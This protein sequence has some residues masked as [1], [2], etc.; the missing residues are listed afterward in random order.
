MIFLEKLIADQHQT[1]V[2]ADEIV[3]RMPQI[4]ETKVYAAKKGITNEVRK[5]LGVLKER[6]DGIENL[7]KERF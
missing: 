6:L 3:H 5:E 7:V 2:L 4:I 1:R